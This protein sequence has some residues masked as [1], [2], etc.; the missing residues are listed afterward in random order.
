LLVL[1]E[2]QFGWV[3]PPF[4]ATPVA[5]SSGSRVLTYN[6]QRETNKVFTHVILWWGRFGARGICCLCVCVYV[7]LD[8]PGEILITP[9]WSVM[10]SWA[11]TMWLT[12]QRLAWGMWTP[13]GPRAENKTIISIAFSPLPLLLLLQLSRLTSCEHSIWIR[14]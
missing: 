1:E 10:C 4:L 6:R 2:K 13:W 5:C 8:H 7:C 14:E 12:C 3:T 11:N 9:C